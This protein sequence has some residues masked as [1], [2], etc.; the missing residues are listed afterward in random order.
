M[1]TLVGVVALAVIEGGDDSIHGC[2]ELPRNVSGCQ[3]HFWGAGR[4]FGWRLQ[5]V[6]SIG[7][8]LC[9]APV[10]AWIRILVKKKASLNALP[11]EIY[12]RF[13]LEYNGFD[14]EDWNAFEES[15]DRE[16]ENEFNMLSS[17]G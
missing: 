1:A 7:A 14:R 11:A 13:V 17:G 15:P 4:Y 12:H 8:R 16:R 2:Y 6:S 5:I 9:S 10:R 3:D